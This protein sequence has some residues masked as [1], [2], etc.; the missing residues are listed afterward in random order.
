MARAGALK[1]LLAGALALAVLAFAAPHATAWWRERAAVLAFQDGLLAIEIGKQ[2][3]LF[4]GISPI[5]KGRTPAHDVALQHWEFDATHALVKRSRDGAPP[6]FGKYLALLDGV[7]ERTRRFEAR[8]RRL[9]ELRA[10]LSG[11]TLVQAATPGTTATAIDA[12]AEAR[13]ISVGLRDEIVAHHEHARRAV[14]GSGLDDHARAAVWRVADEAYVSQLALVEAAERGAP[15]LARMERVL[16]FFADNVD[17]YVV[18][19]RFGLRFRSTAAE[20]RFKQLQRELRRE[21]RREVGGG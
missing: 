6:A 15:E 17:A 10:T 13:R 20:L 12:A 2:D 16:R 21:L 8:V 1:P 18:D 9:D 19:E 4:K 5:D 7:Y 11:L 3:Q 14:A